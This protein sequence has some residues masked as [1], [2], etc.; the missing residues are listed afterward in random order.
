MDQPKA[1]FV[2]CRY[3][4]RL[5]RLEEL[6]LIA[7]SDLVTDWRTK[8]GTPFDPESGLHDVTVSIISSLVILVDTCSEVRDQQVLF[9]SLQRFSGSEILDSSM[10]E[11]PWPTRI[12]GPWIPCPFYTIGT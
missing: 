1:S 11:S 10:S 8:K 2:C 6:T 4:D 7:L 9:H 3:G 12:L 5:K